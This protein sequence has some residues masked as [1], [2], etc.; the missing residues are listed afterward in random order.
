LLAA[1]AFEARVSSVHA[2]PD[3]VEIGDAGA[4]LDTAREFSGSVN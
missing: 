4:R 2:G 3:W 1:A